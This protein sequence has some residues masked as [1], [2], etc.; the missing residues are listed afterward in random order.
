MKITQHGNRGRVT[1]N[2]LD[3][4]ERGCRRAL[5]PLGFADQ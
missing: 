2:A 1:I 5:P 4:D 3:P